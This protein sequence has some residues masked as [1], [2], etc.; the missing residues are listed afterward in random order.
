MS[1]ETGLRL[2]KQLNLEDA[3]NVYIS[4]IYG[5]MPK[6]YYVFWD[7]T[8]PRAVLT[9]RWIQTFANIWTYR[10]ED[11]Y[12]LDFSPLL[13]IERF[14]GHGKGMFILNDVAY[15]RMTRRESVEKKDIRMLCQLPIKEYVTLS[16]FTDINALTSDLTKETTKQRAEYMKGANINTK[17][18]ETDIDGNDIIFKFLT[19]ATE[20][21][22][23]DNHVYQDTN[24][25]SNW[26]LTPNPSKT[27]ELWIKALDVLGEDGWLSV[28]EDQDKI[29]MKDLKLILDSAYV[30]LFSNDPS[31]NW[32]GFAY[33]LTQLDASI[34]PQSIKPQ[35]WDK[36]HGDGEAFL[37]KHFAQLFKQLPFFFNQM[38]SS[39]TGTLQKAGV[40]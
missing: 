36:V 14:G 35:R 23:D 33:W 16:A 37:T 26:I 34:Y 32:Q 15:A 12:A 17:F 39:L 25:E 2:R 28:V 22:Y 4:Y 11:D 19:E 3:G 9:K 13:D 18:I 27:Y 40:I 6:A 38:A 8:N 31:F 29:T 20:G 5:T 30:Q 21:I 1:T 24:P 10:D 7:S